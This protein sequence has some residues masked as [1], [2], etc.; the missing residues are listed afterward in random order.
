MKKLDGDGDGD[1]TCEQ[2]LRNVKARL[3]Q[4][5]V[6]TL[7]QLCNDASDTVLKKLVATTIWRDSID[8]HENGIASVITEL[9]QR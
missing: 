7:R 5:S 6:L 2:T 4:S 9:S 8:I 3:H 1:G